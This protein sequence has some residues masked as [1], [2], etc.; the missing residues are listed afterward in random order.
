MLIY[1]YA[2]SKC[3]SFLKVEPAQRTWK[4][5]KSTKGVQT[6]FPL[7]VPWSK[8]SASTN[9]VIPLFIPGRLSGKMSA[10]PRLSFKGTPIWN[11]AFLKTDFWQN[12]WQ[13]LP[14]GLFLYL[15]LRS[16]EISCHKLPYLSHSLSREKSGLQLKNEI[17]KVSSQIS[18]NIYFRPIRN[19]MSGRI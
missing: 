13:A 15:P 1:H 2:D 17:R 16:M 5:T 14:D 8:V 7:L 19:W 10:Q 18:A 12:G 3:V 4:A 9:R 6:Y 11:Y